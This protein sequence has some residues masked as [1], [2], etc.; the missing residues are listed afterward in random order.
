MQLIYTM[1]IT[2]KR[3]LFHLRWHK[4]LVKHQ[5]VSKHDQNC[6]CNQDK[7]KKTVALHITRLMCCLVLPFRISLE[8]VA[9]YK[10]VH[11]IFAFLHFILTHYLCIQSYRNHVKEIWGSFKDLARVGL[12]VLKKIVIFWRFQNG[13]IDLLRITSKESLFLIS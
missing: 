13:S 12:A 4:N 1:F 11:S 8:L 2:N 3:H 5:N 9:S 10:Q 6:R 7:K